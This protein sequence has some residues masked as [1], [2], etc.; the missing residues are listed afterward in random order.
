[1]GQNDAYKCVNGR[2][3]VNLYEDYAC[4]K[5]KCS[6]NGNKVVTLYT[7]IINLKVN[8]KIPAFS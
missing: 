5:S 4:N 6:N 1:M 3:R 2:Q 7:C 8:S